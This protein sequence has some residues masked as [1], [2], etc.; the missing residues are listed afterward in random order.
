VTQNK[1]ASFLIEERRI[2]T[3]K[4]GGAKQKGEIKKP[5]E[6]MSLRRIDW[7]TQQQPARH[8]TWKQHGTEKKHSSSNSRDWYYLIQQHGRKER[9]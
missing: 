2:S 3:P 9:G 4:P 7:A 8:G 1:S 6:T 5:I